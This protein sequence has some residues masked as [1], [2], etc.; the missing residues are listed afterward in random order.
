MK[1]LVPNGWL[2]AGACAVA[3]V[4]LDAD[5]GYRIFFCLFW[6]VFLP[7]TNVGPDEWLAAGGCA[8]AS[9]SLD[10]DPEWKMFRTNMGPD[11]W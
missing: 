2:A 9:V 1:S 4:S 3:S 7:R 6:T 10:A 8:V 11:E 5:I